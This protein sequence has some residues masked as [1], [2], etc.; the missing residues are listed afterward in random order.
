MTDEI[1]TDGGG[2]VSDSGSIT[3]RSSRPGPR[4]S[5]GQDEIKKPSEGLTIPALERNKGK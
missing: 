4:S 3:S 1:P 2:A 5:K